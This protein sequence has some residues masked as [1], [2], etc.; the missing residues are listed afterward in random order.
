MGLQQST[1]QTEIHRVWSRVEFHIPLQSTREFWDEPVKEYAPATEPRIDLSTYGP[2]ESPKLVT[3]APIWLNPG[4]NP[5]IF[6][7][8]PESIENINAMAVLGL[9]L[10]KPNPPK[11]R[12]PTRAVRIRM[13]LRSN[14]SFDQPTKGAPSN[15]ANCEVPVRAAASEYDWRQPRILIMSQAR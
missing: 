7:H 13:T 9:S 8:L 6:L 12:M 11:P 14:R 4:I 2:V 1:Y 5:T 3:M 10:T 15:A